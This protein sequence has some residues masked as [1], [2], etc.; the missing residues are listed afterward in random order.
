ME[1]AELEQQ[2]KDADKRLQDAVD[3][4]NPVVLFIVKI[5]FPEYRK[6]KRSVKKQ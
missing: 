5:F 2:M 1:K 3:A 6:C 4:T